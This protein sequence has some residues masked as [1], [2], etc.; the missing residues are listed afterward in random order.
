MKE[1][2]SGLYSN[3][4]NYYH[5]QSAFI[6]VWFYPHKYMLAKRCFNP[7]SMLFPYKVFRKQRDSYS[8]TVTNGKVCISY[9]FI[10]KD[11][12]K[13]MVIMLYKCPSKN[14]P[15]ISCLPLITWLIV[16]FS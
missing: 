1:G 4:K 5:F 11:T 15:G 12:V 7:N 6:P 10:V 14:D 16:V 8:C 3:G 2:N 9:K 13:L